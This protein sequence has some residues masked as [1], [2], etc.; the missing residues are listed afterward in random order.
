MFEDRFL[1]VSF[2]SERL[3]SISHVD[4]SDAVCHRIRTLL[5]AGL[6]V[7]NCRFVFLAFSNSQ[8]REHSCWLYCEDDVARDG[9]PSADAI[10]QS[11]GELHILRTPAKF[12][13]RLG[14][15]FSTTFET[16]RFRPHDI[17]EIP[18]VVARNKNRDLF[19][20][21]VG[22]I[23][24]EGMKKVVSKLPMRMRRK[25]TGLLPSAIQIRLGGCKGMLT[26][27]DD[28]PCA[29]TISTSI[30]ICPHRLMP[31]SYSLHSAAKHT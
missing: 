22:V 4:L 10:R 24:S 6:T 3:G 18:D 31:C 17:C 15:G 20:D 30:Y 26:L 23:T 12:A 9:A 27:W 21:G 1:R 16:F 14:Q 29:L 25:L 11:V 19:S 7:G 5:L 8:L 28:V 13:A 2:A